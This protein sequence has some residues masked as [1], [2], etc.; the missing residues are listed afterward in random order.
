MAEN[1]DFADLEVD[2]DA[3]NDLVRQETAIPE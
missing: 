1:L 3:E 2:Q